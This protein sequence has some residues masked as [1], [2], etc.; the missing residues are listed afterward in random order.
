MK[1]RRHSGGGTDGS[2]RGSQEGK[3]DSKPRVM[4]TASIKF[5]PRF[6]SSVKIFNQFRGTILKSRD[7]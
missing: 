1:A 4:N 3:G 6:V 7:E 2:G 5:K